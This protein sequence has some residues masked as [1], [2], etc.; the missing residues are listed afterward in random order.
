MPP[1]YVQCLALELLQD[2][3]LS[4]STGTPSMFMWVPTNQPIKARQ[5]CDNTPSKRD[6]GELRLVSRQLRNAV[7]P[8]LFAE[9]TFNFMKRSLGAIIQQLDDM[10][11]ERTAICHCVRS[12]MIESTDI[13]LSGSVTQG[14]YVTLLKL[15]LRSLLEVRSIWYEY[16]RCLEKNNDD[17]S[18][19]TI[20]RLEGFYNI[21]EGIADLP[22]LEDI[23]FDF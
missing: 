3:V 15:A 9:L 20:P 12:L 11:Q 21:L 22:H 4:V 8:F 7:D 14:T 16:S 6:L 23:Y 18:Q 1:A 17:C 13:G 2:I 19:I 5:E 10:A